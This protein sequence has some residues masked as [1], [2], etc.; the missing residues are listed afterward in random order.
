MLVLLAERQA[1][2]YVHGSIALKMNRGYGTWYSDFTCSPRLKTSVKTTICVNGTRIA[3]AAPRAVCLY[4]T[5]TSR[6][7]RKNRSSW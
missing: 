6:Q 5:F 4:L 7:T 2:K 1:V 3:H